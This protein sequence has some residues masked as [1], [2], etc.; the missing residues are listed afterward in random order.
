MQFGVGQ[1]LSDEVEPLADVRRT[2]A[3][4][5]HIGGPCCISHCFQVKA[6]S[7]E[8]SPSVLARN[9]LSKDCWRAALCDE[10]VEGRPEVPLVGEAFSLARRAERLAGAGAGPDGVVIGPSGKAEGVAPDTDPREEMAL[11]EIAEISSLNG[12]DRSSVNNSIRDMPFL[13]QLPQPG[14]GILVVLVVVSGHAN[15]ASTPSMLSMTTT[16]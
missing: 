1:P 11:S 16:V 5:A 13:D 9:L 14:C 10:P 15:S 2:D 12:D 4:S 6:Y 3:R 7:V 8:P